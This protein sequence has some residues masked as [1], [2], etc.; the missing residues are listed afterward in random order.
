MRSRLGDSRQSAQV[1]LALAELWGVG[2]TDIEIVEDKKAQVEFFLINK[3]ALVVES[4]KSTSSAPIAAAAKKVK[5]LIKQTRR[6]VLPLVAVPFMGEAGRKVCEEM[7][8]GWLDFSGNA[9]ITAPGLCIIVEG[10]PNRFKN[11]GRPAN[12]FAPKSSRLIRWLLIHSSESLTQR[13]ISRGTGLD[14]GFV[15]RLVSRLEQDG[16]LLRDD[17]GG[18]RS[19]DPDLLLDSWRAIYDFSRH[20]VRYYH[21]A[22]RSGEA[23]SQLVTQTLSAKHLEYAATGL[24]AAWVLTHFAGYRISSFYLRSEP[25]SSLL[26]SIEAREEIRGANLWFVVP[27]DDGV[28]DGIVEIDGIKC[29]HPVQAY[30]D[31]KSHPERSSEAAKHLRTK[32]LNWHHGS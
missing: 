2:V 7:D 15:S 29:V 14:E 8:V 10:K 21:V 20:N 28:F 1:L 22:A 6:Q 5:N 31:L 26:E 4:I 3:W 24:A 27:N 18:L 17:R 25:S 19:K 32:L 16:Y 13:E 11:K 23:L 30:L 12:L 9:H